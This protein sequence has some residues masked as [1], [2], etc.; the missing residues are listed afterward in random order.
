MRSKNTTNTKENSKKNSNKI[1]KKKIF[2]L[3]SG[4]EYKFEEAVKVKIGI[5]FT[6]KFKVV[7]FVQPFAA[8]PVKV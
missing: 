8:N 5:E 2:S 7:V 6:V 4:S 3:K 1:S